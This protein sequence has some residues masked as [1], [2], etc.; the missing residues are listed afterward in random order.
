M[1][2]LALTGYAHRAFPRLRAQAPAIAATASWAIEHEQPDIVLELVAAVG[3]L[4]PRVADPLT[5]R[6]PSVEVLQQLETPLDD[7]AVAALAAT[8]FLHRLDQPEVAERLGKR[9]AVEAR[10]I[11]DPATLAIVNDAHAVIPIGRRTVTPDQAAACLA[12]WRAAVDLLVQ[13]GYPAEPQ[14]R[15]GAIL[16]DLLGRFDEAEDML[17]RML[18]FADESRPVVRGLALEM[19]SD[20]SLLLRGDHTAASAACQEAAR[21]L[22]DGGDLDYAAEAELRQAWTHTLADEYDQ[23]EEA[24]RR[25]DEYHSLIGLPPAAEEHPLLIAS[26]A[27]GL[28][29]WDD[30]AVAMRAFFATTPAP[31]DDAGYRAFLVGEPTTGDH[32]VHMIEPLARWLISRDRPDAAANLIAAAPMAFDAT[33]FIAWEQVGDVARVQRLADEL[34]DIQNTDPPTT[35][36]ALYRFMID[37]TARG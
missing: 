15:N 9:L 30:F 33:A 5:L 26:I 21:L 1:R 16:L 36:D 7:L 31:N 29:R 27:A 25:S 2:H 12:Q 34:I 10:H 3:R 32:F 37:C 20:Y 28:D 19:L 14:Y 6:E 23:A 11:T 24:M 22:I 4:W 13:L 17:H 8:A 35:L 18:D